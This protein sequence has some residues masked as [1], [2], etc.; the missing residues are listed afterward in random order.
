MHVLLYPT[1]VMG[2]IA[3]AS[4]YNVHQFECGQTVGFLIAGIICAVGGRMFQTLDRPVA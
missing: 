2:F 1:S 3:A 4:H